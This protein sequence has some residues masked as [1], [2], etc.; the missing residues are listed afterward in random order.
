MCVI[1]PLEVWKIDENHLALSRPW[2][3]VCVF[4][5]M[6]ETISHTHIHTMIAHQ[7]YLS[8][9][10]QYG[11]MCV[12]LLLEFWNINENHLAPRRPGIY[13]CVWRNPQQL[14]FSGLQPDH[15]RRFPT[16]ARRSHQP[17]WL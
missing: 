2:V 11:S 10:S 3:Y 16:A 13:M 9:H 6:V 15:V 8:E 1:L 7:T 5:C 14:R 12:I 4:V 17:V